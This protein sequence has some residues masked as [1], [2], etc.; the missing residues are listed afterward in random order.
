MQTP[1][2]ILDGLDAEQR[3][4]A[5]ALSGPVRILAGAGTG[6]TRAITHRIAYGVATGVYN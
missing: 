5:T 2:I 4:A 3:Q 1:E 6:K